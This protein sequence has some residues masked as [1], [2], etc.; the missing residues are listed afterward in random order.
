[1]IFGKGH[2][3]SFWGPLWPN[4]GNGWMKPVQLAGSRQIGSRE[5]VCVKPYVLPATVAAGK[6]TKA[7]FSGKIDLFFLQMQETV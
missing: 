2:G 4:A 1:M 7:K 3:N 6:G 5:R